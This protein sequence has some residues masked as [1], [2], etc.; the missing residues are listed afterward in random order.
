MFLSGDFAAVG[1]FGQQVTFGPY[2]LISDAS[3]RDS[4]VVRISPIEGEGVLWVKALGQTPEQGSSVRE[5]VARAIAD[6]WQETSYVAGH[7]EGEIVI[8]NRWF[9]SNDVDAFLVKLDDRGSELWVAPIWGEGSQEAVAVATATITESPFSQ[10]EVAYV[11]VWSQRGSIHFHGGSESHRGAMI[12][13]SGRSGTVDWAVG[14]DGTIHDLASS[15]D[16]DVVVVGT[17]RASVNFDGLLLTSPSSFDTGFIV[18]YSSAGRPLWARMIPGRGPVRCREVEVTP[19]GEV[20]VAGTFDTAATFG[21]VEKVGFGGQDVFLL[22][23]GP[24]GSW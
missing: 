3:D 20:V 4:F 24:D 11:G 22:R 7:Y 17:F 16:G 5:T 6:G 18:K 13:L 21:L 15:P 14:F 10:R 2:D 9:R 8:A 12:Q 19:L 1:T 23:L